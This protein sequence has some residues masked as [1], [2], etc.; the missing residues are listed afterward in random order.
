MHTSEPITSS[1][2]VEGS[3][4]LIEL[5]QLGGEADGRNGETSELS[6]G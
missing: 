1:S 6:R 5:K 3:A 4:R 2:T